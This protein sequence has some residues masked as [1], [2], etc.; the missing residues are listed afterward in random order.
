ML[1]FIR[2]RRVN[3]EWLSMH[4]CIDENCRVHLNF[5]TDHVTING[6]SRDQNGEVRNVH[7]TNESDGDPP[8]DCTSQC[9]STK[10]PTDLDDAMGN[11]E[12]INKNDI[13]NL[14]H[15][16]GGF[17]MIAQCYEDKSVTSDPAEDLKGNGDVEDATLNNTDQCVNKR[18]TDHDKPMFMCSWLQNNTDI[19]KYP[20]YKLAVQYGNKKCS[21]KDA[22]VYSS[23]VTDH[24]WTKHKYIG[25]E[26]NV[27]SG[28]CSARDSSSSASRSHENL[29]PSVE[30][31]LKDI[32]DV[33]ISDLERKY[34]FLFDPNYTNVLKN[35]DTR[36]YDGTCNNLEK[37][38]VTYNDARIKNASV[39]GD[40]KEN[41]WT[42]EEVD[43]YL[44][45][46][47]KIDSYGT[48]RQENDQE[49]AQKMNSNTYNF[50]E[51]NASYY[52]T[53]QSE[54]DRGMN[55]EPASNIEVNTNTDRTKSTGGDINSPVNYKSHHQHTNHWY[56]CMEGTTL[57]SHKLDS[58]F[59]PHDNACV[60][61]DIQGDFNSQDVYWD[62]QSPP[63]PF[64]AH[65]HLENAC[66]VS[67]AH[68]QI[69]DLYSPYSPCT[70]E[71]TYH[72]ASPLVRSPAYSYYVSPV[73]YQNSLFATGNSRHYF[74]K[75][76]KDPR[77]KTDDKNDAGDKEKKRH[78]DEV[79]AN[80]THRCSDFSVFSKSEDHHEKEENSPRATIHE[81]QAYEDDPL[82]RN[83][84]R[85]NY[86]DNNSSSPNSE[87]FYGLNVHQNEVHYHEDDIMDLFYG[88]KNCSERNT[89]MLCESSLDFRQ[90]SHSRRSRHFEMKSCSQRDRETPYERSR[91][92]E[93]FNEYRRSSSEEVS[94]RISRDSHHS[95]SPRKN[96]RIEEKYE[97]K[98]D[99]NEYRKRRKD[100]N[101]QRERKLNE[102]HK[103]SH[104]R[105][106][107][108]HSRSPV[109]SFSRRKERS[110]SPSVK[111]RRHS[112]RRAI[113]R[114]DFHFNRDRNRFYRSRE[115]CRET[116]RPKKRSIR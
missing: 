60:N 94:R 103:Y 12:G 80:D 18:T 17:T 111:K 114:T 27:T 40:L 31:V 74:T 108:R 11:T 4:Q 44:N 15:K 57:V 102:R 99:S 10:P 46:I 52:Q 59:D 115:V 5:N 92:R 51:S 24:I 50:K 67:N 106:M 68:H 96:R 39:E 23:L 6:T 72:N 90:D 93:T 70:T 89:A 30:A 81:G 42:I 55:V 13:V 64:S 71:W 88:E 54:H 28:L 79:S 109:I 32:P 3:K 33:D 112:T 48:N 105:N 26:D 62:S 36:N 91:S 53:I 65:S 61:S 75:R 56:D 21:K 14:L 22:A 113:I 7:L 107:S 8:N 82:Y 78:Y 35:N 66:V 98:C 41:A 49:E 110:R 101:K 25:D 45:G 95:M 16:S 43:N 77:I 19:N 69:H 83:Y 34:S 84:I 2:D 104:E 73:R 87:I 58:S 1:D 97:R 38:N 116:R 37:E 63:I 47:R 20:F 100:Q 29:S 76:V 9:G 86:S 85:L